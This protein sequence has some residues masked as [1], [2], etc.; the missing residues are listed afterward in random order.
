MK[1]RVLA[2]ILVLAMVLGCAPSAF[3][4]VP[5]TNNSY[6]AEQNKLAPSTGL[7]ENEAEQ[8][9]ETEV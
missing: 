7:A 6:V 9:E 4:A 2:L 8:E 1:K 5:L 3:A